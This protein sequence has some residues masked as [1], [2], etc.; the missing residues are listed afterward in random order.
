MKQ[1]L[2]FKTSKP[3]N[4]KFLKFFSYLIVGVL[5]LQSCADDQNLVNHTSNLS[6]EQ[7]LIN[8]ISSDINLVVDGNGNT[9]SS[10]ITS[11]LPIGGPDCAPYTI[12]GLGLKDTI[13]IAGNCQAVVMWDEYLCFGQAG[14][15]Y[16]HTLIIDNFT[17]TPIAGQCD[18]ILL[19]WQALQAAGKT[20]E[21]AEAIDQFIYDASVILEGI[22]V[23]EHF[24]GGTWPQNF[25]TFQCNNSQKYF[26]AESYL[27]NCYQ[28]WYSYEVSPAYIQLS[29]GESCC[30]R[31]TRYCT[32]KSGNVY[33]LVNEEPEI[34]QVGT[35]GSESNLLAPSQLYHKVGDCNHECK[36]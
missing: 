1:L 24:F 7:G 26:T 33:N 31:K 16:T 10:L 13:T 30:V 34:S 28:L 25:N 21:L 36:G 11:C 29:C 17:V 5:M 2:F 32:I 15:N 22:R 4:L 35:C 3:Q 14:Q 9:T 27:A 12:I 8:N 18:S 6:S 19:A 20:N 23:H